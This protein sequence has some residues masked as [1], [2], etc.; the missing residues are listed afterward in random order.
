MILRTEWG[1]QSSLP[2]TIWVAELYV[3]ERVEQK[4]IQVHHLDLADIEDE[5]RCKAGLQ[6]HWDQDPERGLRAIVTIYLNGKRVAV[7][8]YPLV[9]PRGDEWNLGSAYCIT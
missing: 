2:P 5:V 1:A 9:H 4:I 7:I 3:S 6:F 8:L